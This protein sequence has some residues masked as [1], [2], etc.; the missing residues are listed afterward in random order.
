MSTILNDD[1]Q[2]VVDAARFKALQFDLT[3]SAETVPGIVEESA[4]DEGIQ[5]DERQKAEACDELVNAPARTA[6]A[7]HE[8]V[9]AQRACS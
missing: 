7:I 8:A 5:L 1:V 2:D 3:I 9:A 4:F 6:D